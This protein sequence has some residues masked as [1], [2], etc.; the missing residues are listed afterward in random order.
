MK[1]ALCLSGGGFKSAFQ[2]G[3]L[4]YLQECDIKYDLIAGISAGALNG[5]M[6]ATDN[7]EIL[8]IIWKDVGE[9]GSST[10][11]DSVYVDLDDNLKIKL[12][13]IYKYF[14]KDQSLLS[15][16]TKGGRKRFEYKLNNFSSLASSTP[17]AKL[18]ENVKLE[19]FK[20]PFITGAVSLNNG[21]LY[22]LTNKDFIADIEIRKFIEAS[23]TMPIICKPISKVYTKNSILTNLVDGGVR[24]ISPLSQIFEYIKNTEEDWRII[25]IN[26]SSSKLEPID[27]INNIG[28]IGLRSLNDIALNQISRNDLNTANIIN[29]FVK[30]SRKKEINGYRY[31]PLTVISPEGINIG[32]TLD[33]SKEIIK[34]RIKQGYKITKQIW[35]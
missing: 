11:F 32:D 31:Y 1:T 12:K 13:E 35:K 19:D 24:S 29:D 9:K 28:Q 25:V 2:Y 7:F 18:L 21:E 8:D 26:C 33:S 27:N 20:I 22:S 14:F 16:L 3:A 15:L 30:R 23:A 4:K 17:L 34:Y 10:I 6:I 5:S